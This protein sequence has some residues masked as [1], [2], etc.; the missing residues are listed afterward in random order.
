MEYHVRFP[1]RARHRTPQTDLSVRFGLRV[2][3]LERH[4]PV[5]AVQFRVRAFLL[6]RPLY[7]RGDMICV[8]AVCHRDRVHDGNGVGVALVV[9]VQALC[10]R[11]QL[12]RCGLLTRAGLY[13]DSRP[14]VVA[15]RK[16]ARLD[17]TNRVLRHEVC[18]R[19]A[20]YQAG[21]INEQGYGPE[22]EDANRPASN[23]E[24]A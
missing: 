6:D 10:F 1:V 9:C 24:S 3:F 20:L 12:L 19:C 7:T 18:N 16:G 11:R 21:S 13:C 4:R 2:L 17:L 15:V 5:N 22:T 14:Q 8:N 23:Q